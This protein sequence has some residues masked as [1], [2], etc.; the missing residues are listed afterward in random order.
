MGCVAS[1]PAPPAANLA[2]RMTT[3]PR[4]RALA[5]PSPA[6]AA[7]VVFA[8]VMVAPQIFNDGDT[9]WHVAAGAWMLDHR[10]VLK[11]DIFSYSRFGAPWQTHD[12]ISAI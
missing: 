6:A 1:I 7:V 11:T 5:P 12:A 3:A 10:Q 8:L 2:A 4:L 9:Y